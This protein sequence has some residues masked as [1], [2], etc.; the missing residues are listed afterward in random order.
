MRPRVFPAEDR[1]STAR[2]LHAI[3]SF[4]EAAG[5]PRG[6]LWRCTSL[7]PLKPGFNEAAGIPRGRH[8]DQRLDPTRRHASMRPRV[9]PAEDRVKMLATLRGLP[10]Q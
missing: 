3:S 4:N 5:I 2:P 10:L 6:R 7:Q 8:G 1:Q 9:F